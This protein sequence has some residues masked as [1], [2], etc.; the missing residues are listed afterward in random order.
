[1]ATPAQSTTIDRLELVERACRAI[2]GSPEVPSLASLAAGTRALAA[3]AIGTDPH[4]DRREFLAMID[5][6]KRLGARA[7][8]P[9]LKTV[10]R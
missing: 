10:A 4:G 7:G 6:A 2:E 1:M 8:Q 3:G 5:Q 9:V